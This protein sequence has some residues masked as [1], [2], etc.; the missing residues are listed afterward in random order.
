MQTLKPTKEIT[1]LI[2]DYGTFISVAE[3]LAETMKKVYYY[4]PYEKEYQDVRECCVGT[5]LDKVERLDNYFDPEVF[6]TIDLFVFPDIGFGSLQK[7]LRSLGKAV[8]GQMGVSED[9]ELSRDGFLDTLKKLGLKTVHSER[10]VGMTALRTHLKANKNKWIK[11]NRYR[12]NMETWHHLDYKHSERMLDSMDVTFGG[13]KETPIF[14]V[15]D[16]LKSDMETGCDSW[17]IDGKFPSYSF[18]G[19]EKKNELYLASVVAKK[20]LS[21]EIKSINDAI[22]PLLKEYGYRNWWATEIRICKGEPYFIDPTPRMPGMSGEHQMET[23]S[24]F[25]DIIWQGANGVM[26]EP[27]FKW[28]FAA[29]ATLHYGA[30][31]SDDAV[32][33]EWKTL[34]IPKE[35]SQWVKLYHYCKIDGAYHF[36]PDGKD[37][38][39]VVIGVGNSIQE[40]LDNIKKNLDLLKEL[41]ISAE[42]AGF[43]DLLE[44]IKHAEE[45]GIK[46]ADEVP[47]PEVVVEML[48][49]ESEEKK[50]EKD[51]GKKGLE[52]EIFGYDF[53]GVVSEGIVP[54]KG[55]V[56]ITGRTPDYKE[57]TKKEMDK[58][59]VSAPVKFYPRMD[60]DGNKKV[61]DK[62][63]AEHK[64]K[65]IKKAGVTQF[66]E[67]TKLQAEIIRKK[68]K[69]KVIDIKSK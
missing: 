46:F 48:T 45:E 3:K 50:D 43:V 61:R 2:I 37:E 65:E 66:H 68:A 7:H 58:M 16:E 25:A 28:K 42:I 52:K 4:S 69:I 10:I 67:D 55:G 56:I 14:I 11:I 5:G 54:K 24:N 18:Q 39:G 38:V 32:S 22:A 51:S 9:L 15:Q 19:Y 57:Q 6:D 49:G 33:K 59:G 13:A 60:L 41:P 47:E 53:D 34:I 63:I 40:S 29:E 12:H 44:S 62:Q 1:A 17:C 35:V 30:A 64:V 20:E 26:V 27:E 8:W 31:A 36:V 21:D 23:I